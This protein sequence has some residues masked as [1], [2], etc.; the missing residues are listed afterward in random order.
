MYKRKLNPKFWA[1]VAGILAICYFY[2]R[3]L[4]SLLGE[5]NPWTSYFYMYGFGLVTFS[6]GMFVILKSGALNPHRGNERMW[7]HL[8][9]GGFVFFST[10][11]GIW[12]ILA[13]NIPYLGGGIQ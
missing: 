2:P 4:V 9:L 6:V 1:V 3:A 7:M 11:H 13:L 12:I 8:L 5:D 10:F